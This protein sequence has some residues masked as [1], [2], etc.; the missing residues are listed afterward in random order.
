MGRLIDIAY[1]VI[2]GGT[3]ALCVVRLTLNYGDAILTF[4]SALFAG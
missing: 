2:F 3:G 4:L 1:V